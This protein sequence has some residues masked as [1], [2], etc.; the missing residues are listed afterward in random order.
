MN[1]LDLRIKYKSQTGFH[2]TYGNGYNYQGT[3]TKHYV[4][5]LENNDKS[6]RDEYKRNT[7]NDATWEKYVKGHNGLY[8][9]IYTKEYKEWLEEFW[10]ESDTKICITKKNICHKIK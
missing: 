5:W 9:T 6:F 1:A 7:G 8:E 10:Y 3:L 4:K 2:P